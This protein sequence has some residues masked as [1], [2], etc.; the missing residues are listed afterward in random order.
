MIF[1]I[2]EYDAGASFHLNTHHL[3]N[4]RGV[5]SRKERRC[6]LIFSSRIQGVIWALIEDNME[7]RNHDFSQDGDKVTINR[8]MGKQICIQFAA[9]FPSLQFG[10]LIR[11]RDGDLTPLVIL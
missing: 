6:P 7:E 10:L 5:H 3:I 1:S 9:E 11:I 4:T 8:L 2:V